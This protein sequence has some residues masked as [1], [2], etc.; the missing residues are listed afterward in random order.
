MEVA[1]ILLKLKNMRITTWAN[2]KTELEFAILAGKN[3]INDIL[4]GKHSVKDIYL[5]Y[6]R[7]LEWISNENTRNLI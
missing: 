2:R 5:I 3:K 7:H 4:S 6:C 1:V